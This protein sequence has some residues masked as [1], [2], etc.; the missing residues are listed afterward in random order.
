MERVEFDENNSSDPK[1][2]RVNDGTVLKMRMLETKRMYILDCQ[3]EFYVWFGMY[4]FS[5]VCLLSSVGWLLF[6]LRLCVWSVWIASFFSF[7]LCEEE[8]LVGLLL[9]VFRSPYFAY[10]SRFLGVVVLL[11]PLLPLSLSSSPYLSISPAPYSEAPEEQKAAALEFAQGVFAGR[12]PTAVAAAG[13]NEDHWQRCVRVAE[14]AET[15]LFREKF[16][17][18]PDMANENTVRPRFR[19]HVAAAKV[20]NQVVFLLFASGVG[21]CCSLSLSLSFIHGLS[22][23]GPMSIHS[24]WALLWNRIT[25]TQAKRLSKRSTASQTK[26]IWTSFSSCFPEYVSLFPFDCLFVFFLLFF[27]WLCCV[28]SMY[29]Y[30]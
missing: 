19:K 27:W 23:Y 2:T 15:I 25:S 10:D 17:D 29:L 7:S 13:E 21:L 1:C 20:R 4:V 24:A 12:Y 30:A 6:S 3:N 11:T 14:G 18:W 9:F 16:S 5:P 22:G 28:C 26:M 8:E